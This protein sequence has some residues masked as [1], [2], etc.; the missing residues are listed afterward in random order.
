MK[1]LV[2]ILDMSACKV[3]RRHSGFPFILYSDW[4]TTKQKVY[5]TEIVWRLGFA[6]VIFQWESSDFRKY[7][8]V[9]TLAR[10]LSLSLCFKFLFFSF[11]H[12]TTP[13]AAVYLSF[14][15]S[16][17]VSK[18]TFTKQTHHNKVNVTLIMLGAFL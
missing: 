8:C 15:I 18:T 7:V 14:H 2:K 3:A 6:D 4:S 12:L 10:R 1:N 13:Q 11:V 5:V 9:R 16:A 17:K